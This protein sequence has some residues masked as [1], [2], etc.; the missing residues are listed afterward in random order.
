MTRTRRKPSEEQLKE[1]IKDA[2][3]NQTE[4]E[5]WIPSDWTENPPILSRI[6]DPKF[7]KFAKNLTMLWKTLA[8]KIKIQVKNHPERHSLIYANNGFIIPGGRFKGLFLYKFKTT[9]RI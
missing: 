6:D 1:F 3:T 5:E 2:F 7:Q 8:R 4:L 9:S